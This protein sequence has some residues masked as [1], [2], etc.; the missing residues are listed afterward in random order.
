MGLGTLREV[1]D[2]SGDPREVRDRSGYR[3]VRSGGSGEAGWSGTGWGNLTEVRDVLG[4]P[5]EGWE[6]FGGPSLGSGTG[7]QTLGEVWN[8]SGYHQE[9]A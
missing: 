1:Q 6:R 9:G 3:L 2:G 7:R 5:Q 4:D 8:G